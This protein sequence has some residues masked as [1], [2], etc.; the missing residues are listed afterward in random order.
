MRTS[1]GQRCQECGNECGVTTYLVFALLV[2]FVCEVTRTNGSNSRK[3]ATA[4]L[5]CEVKAL[6]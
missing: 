3:E 4:D 2:L 5:R 1:K 6:L